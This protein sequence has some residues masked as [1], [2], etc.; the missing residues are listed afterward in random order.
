MQAFT[1]GEKIYMDKNEASYIFRKEDS[2][3]KRETVD[4]S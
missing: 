3:T 4:D 2:N 1:I